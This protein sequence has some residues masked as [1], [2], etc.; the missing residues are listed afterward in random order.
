LR[1][2]GVSPTH[3]SVGVMVRGPCLMTLSPV[4]AHRA[5]RDPTLS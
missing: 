5:R 1:N 3:T 4:C 2:P